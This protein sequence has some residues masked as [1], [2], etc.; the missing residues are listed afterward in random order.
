MAW[1]AVGIVMSLLAHAGASSASLQIRPC[2]AALNPAAATL[3]SR[4]AVAPL[5]QIDDDDDDAF[6][7]SITASDCKCN[8]P[9]D[10]THE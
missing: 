5:M 1:T 2:A 9:S 7:E 3:A 8:I 4:R 10:L 6:A